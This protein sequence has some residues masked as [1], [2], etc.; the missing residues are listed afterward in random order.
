MEMLTP[1]KRDMNVDFKQ[2]RKYLEECMNN[3]KDL[4]KRQYTGTKKL[5]EVEKNLMRTLKNTDNDKNV[6]NREINRL[7]HIDRLKVAHANSSVYNP[8]TG[9]MLP[10]LDSA[11]ASGSMAGFMTQ[12]TGAQ[13]PQPEMQSMNGSPG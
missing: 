13:T 12:F 1:L 7:Q 3:I 4:Q 9:C 8:D 11:H 6:L 5:D 2:L 10:S